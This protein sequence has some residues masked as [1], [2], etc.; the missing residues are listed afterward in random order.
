ME[1]SELV[2][3]VRGCTLNVVVVVVVVVAASHDELGADARERKKLG[4]GDKIR[5]EKDL[6]ASEFRDR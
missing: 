3:G 4:D 6:R 5:E 2:A 1:V